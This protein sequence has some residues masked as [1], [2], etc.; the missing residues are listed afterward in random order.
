MGVTPPGSDRYNFAN[1]AASCR[2]I[3]GR[4]LLS[5]PSRSCVVSKSRIFRYSSTLQNDFE[6]AKERLNTLKEDP[7][8]ET[9]L[10]IYALFKQVR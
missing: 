7:G 4:V 8:N 5:Q 9:K 6:K 10:K 2:R 1:M 3:F